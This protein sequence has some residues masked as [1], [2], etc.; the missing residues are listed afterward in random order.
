MKHLTWP[1]IT[2]PPGAGF[3]SIKNIGLAFDFAK[4]IEEIPIE[5]IKSLL[6]DFN[7]SLHVLNTAKQDEFD[8]NIVFE[9]SMLEEVMKPFK[10]NCHFITSDDVDKGIMDFAD[11]NNIDLLMVLPKRHGLVERLMHKSLSKQM[12]LHS[13]I[14]VMA[15]HQS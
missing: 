11:K 7:A 3:S 14:P 10:P 6:K 2:V 13:H 4:M 12:V 9:S 5:E 1:V 8:A 15:L